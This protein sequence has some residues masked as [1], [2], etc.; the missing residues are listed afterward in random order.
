MRSCPPRQARVSQDSWQL[1]VS[2]RHGEDSGLQPFDITGGETDRGT[3]LRDSRESATAVRGSW[4]S[5]TLLASIAGTLGYI[6]KRVVDRNSV[7]AGVDAA[8]N[9][10]GT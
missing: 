5:H 6:D 7:I 8:G 1:G 2:H 9:P 3:V 10:I 4:D